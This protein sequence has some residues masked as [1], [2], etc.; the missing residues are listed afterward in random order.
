M[1]ALIAVA[2]GGGLGAVFR[3]SL[4]AALGTRLGSG[5][6][7]GTMCV[8][9][10]GSFLIGV[11]YV[12]LM[13]RFVSVQWIRLVLIT[14]FLG[15]FTT[16]SAFSL[17]ALLLFEGGLWIRGLVYSLLSVILCLGSTVLGIWITRALIRSVG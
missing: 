14:G 1:N 6:P 8:N 2:I 10:L 5:F 13:E 11:A 7:W 9:V 4:V 15:G 12:I 17:D 3:Y 16:F